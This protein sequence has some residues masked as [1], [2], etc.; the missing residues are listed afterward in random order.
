MLTTCLWAPTNNALEMAEYYCSVFPDSHITMTG[1]Y[2]EANP[3]VAGSKKWDVLIVEFTL[4][5]SEKFSTLN[6]W[7]YFQ[8]SCAVSFM[9]PCASQTD[10]DYYYDR[11]SAV[12][13]AEQCGWVTDR[14]WVSWQLVPGNFTRYMQSD[15][16]EKKSRLMRALMD[17]HRLSWDA[18]EQAYYS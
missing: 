15:E 6:G 5:G 9:I 18:I 3:H 1:L 2:D 16:T 13:E 8:H 17:M 11:L 12:P 10:L 7:P 4:L 14:F